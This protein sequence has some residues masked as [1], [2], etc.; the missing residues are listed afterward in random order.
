MAVSIVLGADV[1]HLVN[2]TALGAALDGAFAGH[3]CTVS[4]APIIPPRIGAAHG[5]GT[6]AEPDNVVRVSRVTSA[7]GILLLA[8]RADG[9]GILHGALAR[10]IQR[11]HVED[12]DALHLAENLETLD[13]G[14]LLQVR[15]HGTLLGTGAEK[16][17]YGLDIC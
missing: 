9:D 5:R 17:I 4:S 8:G 14:R 6:H 13:T 1:V 12:I 10:S 7:A 3:L 11:P 16:V 2:T 15:G